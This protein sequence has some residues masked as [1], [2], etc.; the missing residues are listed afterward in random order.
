VA[1]KELLIFACAMGDQ[2]SAFV[3][4]GDVLDRGLI[5][6]LRSVV[7]SYVVFQSRARAADG[8]ATAGQNISGDR[9]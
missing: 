5:S 3:V 1:S 8:T 4:E 6:F 9:T 2:R 7:I